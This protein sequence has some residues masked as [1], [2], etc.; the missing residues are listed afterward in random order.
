MI[1]G[2][3]YLF[4]QGGE[5][6]WIDAA[7]LVTFLLASPQS[8]CRDAEFALRGPFRSGG[9]PCGCIVK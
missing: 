3:S 8:H 2:E 5:E 6:S 7:C 4:A 1:D 9:I